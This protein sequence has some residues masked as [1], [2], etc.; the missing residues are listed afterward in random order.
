MGQMSRRFNFDDFDALCAEALGERPEPVPFTREELERLATDQAE[1]ERVLGHMVM[2]GEITAE[3]AYALVDFGDPAF[4]R[5]GQVGSAPTRFTSGE[6]VG[7]S[8]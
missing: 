3:E 8:D 4:R 1:A 7:L 6:T 5:P 2:A